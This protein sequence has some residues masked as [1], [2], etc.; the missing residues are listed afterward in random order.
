V[1]RHAGV[2]QQSLPSRDARLTVG[3]TRAEVQMQL[4]TQVV[5][6]QLLVA[7]ELMTEAILIDVRHLVQHPDVHTRQPPARSVVR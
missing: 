5:Q 1:R 3:S 7:A 4:L 2:C 6:R